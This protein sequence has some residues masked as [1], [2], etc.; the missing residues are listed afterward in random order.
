MQTLINSTNTGESNKELELIFVYPV[1]QGSWI[2]QFKFLK[3]WQQNSILDQWY[4]KN[5]INIFS[6]FVTVVINHHHV[7]ILSFPKE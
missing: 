4:L 1:N 5:Y 7:W 6:T 3:E 2:N